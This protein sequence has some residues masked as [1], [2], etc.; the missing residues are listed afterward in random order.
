MKNI[1]YILIGILIATTIPVIGY[2]IEDPI[3]SEKIKI[4]EETE[5]DLDLKY[6]STTFASLAD[7]EK[8]K[9]ED[10]RHQTELRVLNSIYWELRKLN[11][12]VQ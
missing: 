1:L 10:V 6:A 11:E 2:Y 4:L 5:S 8:T 12:K 9:I 3:T 7:Y